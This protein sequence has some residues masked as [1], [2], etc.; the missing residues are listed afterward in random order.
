MTKALYKQ[1]L[2]KIEENLMYGD[3]KSSKSQPKLKITDQKSLKHSST[4]LLQDPITQSRFLD[5]DFGENEES[6]HIDKINI[7]LEIY[8]KDLYETANPAKAK[9]VK[10]DQI[11]TITDKVARIPKEIQNLGRFVERRHKLFDSKLQDSQN[12]VHSLTMRLKD[13]ESELNFKT[14]ELARNESMVA[15]KGPANSYSRTLPSGGKPNPNEVSGMDIWQL[16]EELQ[17]YTNQKK[18][19]DV[20]IKE[21]REKFLAADRATENV[22][23]QMSS[24]NGQ[25]GNM[26][27]KEKKDTETIEKLHFVLGDSP[28]GV[29]EHGKSFSKTNAAVESL[30]RQLEQL[31]RAL[32]AEKMFTVTLKDEIK[33]QGETIKKYADHVGPVD[34]IDKKDGEGFGFGLDNLEELLGFG[35]TNTMWDDD[36][37]DK[38]QTSNVNVSNWDFGANPLSTEIESMRSSFMLPIP[39]PRKFVEFSGQTD[40][41][42]FNRAENSSQTVTREYAGNQ[43]QTE[44]R[45][46]VPNETQTLVVETFAQSTET[47]VRNVVESCTTTQGLIEASDF[48]VQAQPFEIS[49]AVTQV[50]ILTTNIG[51]QTDPLPP[52]EP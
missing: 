48:E 23:R 51:F 7:Q 42:T 22:Q 19:D 32:G 45:E 50:E 26:I 47:E 4:Y 6:D 8:I 29:D 41:S 27:E 13:L 17:R 20:V 10:T 12:Q 34:M 35:G 31:E 5:D 18:A 15:N 37:L 33:Q 36:N 38:A 2:D 25:I 9:S 49:D 28:F 14:E 30:Q 3:A 43:T 39:V 46:T 24:L 40:E 1:E 52:P 44:P 21:W 16:E 11:K